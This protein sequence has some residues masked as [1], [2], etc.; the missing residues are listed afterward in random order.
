MA[1][2]LGRGG[3]ARPTLAVAEGL[4]G[5]LLV[6]E[7]AGGP[8][9]GRIVEVEAYIGVDDP[10][11]HAAAGRTARNRAMWGPPGHAYIYFTYGM[12][13]CLN[14]VTEREGFPAAVLIRALAPEL[15][16]ER[17]R[18]ARPHL[19]ERRL[20]SGPGRVGAGLGLTR[21]ADGLDL[22]TGPLW[23]SRA[24]RAPA[25]VGR[26]PRVGIRAG[27][28]RPWR[29]FVAGDPAVSGPARGTGGSGPARSAR[30]RGAG[31]RRGRRPGLPTGLA[32]LRG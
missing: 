12:H 10:A 1:A 2:R 30:E 18:R 28:D 5:R 8:V 7:G 13:H 6:Y 22:T 4:L 15:G 23:V 11:C 19:P 14:L 29:L 17:L 3:F 20:L 25:A 16:I 21:A 27:L 9:G 24:R 32:R 26:G 31:G